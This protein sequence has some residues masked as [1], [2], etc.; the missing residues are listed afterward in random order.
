ML[1]KIFIYDYNFS[2]KDMIKKIKQKKQELNLGI[3]GM[4]ISI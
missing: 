1:G 3:T 4:F 2:I